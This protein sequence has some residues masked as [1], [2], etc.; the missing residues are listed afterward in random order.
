MA[1]Q[2]QARGVSIADS[3]DL[4]QQATEGSRSVGV[5]RTLCRIQI[6]AAEVKNVTAYRRILFF[7]YRVQSGLTIK[8]MYHARYW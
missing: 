2:Q 4:A 7:K 5:C 6:A 1:L 8:Q 3:P